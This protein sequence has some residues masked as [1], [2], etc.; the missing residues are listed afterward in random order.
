MQHGCNLLQLIHH[1]RELLW[2]DRLRAVGERLFRLV[3]DLNHNAV[4]AHCYGRAGHW[5]NL[6][7]LAGSVARVNQDRQMAE[8]LHG[9]DNAQ[10][11]GVSSMVGKGADTALAQDH[12][13]VAFAHNVFGRH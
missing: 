13:I 5:N 12:L 9:R 2:I 7:A 11:K 8:S 4:R 3:V 6:I 10:V 1:R